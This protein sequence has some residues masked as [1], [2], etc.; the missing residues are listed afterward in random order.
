[1]ASITQFVQRWAESMTRFAQI[2]ENGARKH[3]ALHTVCVLCIG[4]RR[5]GYS[6]LETLNSL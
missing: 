6:R 4:R 5:P 3:W 2:A 1:M